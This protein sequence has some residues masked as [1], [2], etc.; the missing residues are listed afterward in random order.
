MPLSSRSRCLRPRAA[1]GP[2]RQSVKATDE[3]AKEFASRLAGISIEHSPEYRI[4][5]LLTG[6]EPVAD[7]SASGVPIVFHT[8]ARTTRAQA[9]LAMR[10]HLIDLRT[11]CPARA[12]QAMTS[13]QAKSCCSSPLQTRTA[14]VPTR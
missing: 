12:A 5:V 4:V 11:S 9:I 3:I 8:G 1:C 13:G 14:L 7:R 2:N 6:T 10:Q